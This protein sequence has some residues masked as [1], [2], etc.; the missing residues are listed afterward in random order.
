MRLLF[1]TNLPSPYRVDFFNELG[2]K[3]ELTVCFERINAVDRDLLW[4]ANSVNRFNEIYADV[5]P[6]FNDKSVGFGIV[7]VIKNTSF[8]K[9]II[10]GYASPSVILAIIYC[11]IKKIKY[12]IEGDG[13]FNHN[14]LF[15]KY[16]AKKCLLRG[17]QGYFTTCEEY[18]NYL[19]KNGINRDLI[20]KYPF[21]SIKNKDI[22]EKP[23]ALEE[24]L[25]LKKMLG[26]KEKKIILSVGQYI[27]RKGF[28]ILLDATNLLPKE[29]GV[30]IVGGKPT[31]E[32]ISLREKFNLTNVYFID[33]K[34]KKELKKWYM[35][36]DIFV[37]PTRED[38]WGLVINEAMACGLPI[39]TTDRCIA[40]LEMIDSKFIVPTN[41]SYE[42][43][44]MINMVICNQILRQKMAE[45]NIKKIKD[46]TIEKMCD[47]HMKELEREISV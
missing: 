9:L 8:D 32:L 43:A 15:L 22:L 11:K 35:A 28:D 20:I 23:V 36:A 2:K 39:I 4:K 45:D 17:A 12:Y 18:I 42:L 38:V 46:Y 26:I 6:I 7:K 29:I 3:C 25:E 24:K 16:L 5:K 44:K 31:K 19:T 1:I 40:G 41:N 27:Y 47:V 33:F 21:S 13:G 37:F 10:S 30:Y 14:D 34:E